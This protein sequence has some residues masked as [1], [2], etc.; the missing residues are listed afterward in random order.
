M[1]QTRL[2]STNSRTLAACG[3]RLIGGASPEAVDREH[4]RLA[5]AESR[6]R[7]EM[8][9]SRSTRLTRPTSRCRS[10]ASGCPRSAG[11]STLS[12][13]IAAPGI[14]M[15]GPQA[16][17]VT[18]AVRGRARRS[19]PGLI[20][21]LLT[22]LSMNMATRRGLGVE[23]LLDFDVEPALADQVEADRRAVRAHQHDVARLLAG[24][25]ERGDGRDR[26]MRGMAEDQVDVGIG[27]HLVGD[28]RAGVASAS[29]CMAGSEMIL[30]SGKAF[31]FSSKPF[32][33]S[34]V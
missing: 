23:R 24:R 34:S 5:S 19:S 18:V 28:D 32:W 16:S 14:L 33:M 31:I 25:L 10:A 2:S 21:C 17:L 1:N 30:T 7:A 26:Q 4:A 6:R 22:T 12:L 3:V 15:F 27:E 11:S 8:A 29:H 20:S 13:V 9:R